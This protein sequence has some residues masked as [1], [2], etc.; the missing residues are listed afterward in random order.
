MEPCVVTGLQPFLQLMWVVQLCY[1][2]VSLSKGRAS[3]GV[4]SLDRACQKGVSENI[5]AFMG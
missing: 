1:D 4:D 2:G 3:W 5:T